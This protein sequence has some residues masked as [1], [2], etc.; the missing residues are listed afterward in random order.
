VIVIV[1]VIVIVAK[2]NRNPSMPEQ[3]SGHKRLLWQCLKLQRPLTLN[4]KMLA[5]SIKALGILD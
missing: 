3:E 2:G 1:I 4:R 5:L